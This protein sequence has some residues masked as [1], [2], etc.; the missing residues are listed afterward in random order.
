[1]HLVPRTLHVSVV[2]VSVELGCARDCQCSSAVC[3]SAFFR[4]PQ[5]SSGAVQCAGRA[6]LVLSASMSGLQLYLGCVG[7]R[8]HRYVFAVVARGVPF[9]KHLTY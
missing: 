4:A 5:C 3:W 8:L 6:P 1:M 9:F 2:V 7:G